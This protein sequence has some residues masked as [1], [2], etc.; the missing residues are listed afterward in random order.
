ML[1]AKSYQPDY[2]VEAYLQSID[3]V[4]IEKNGRNYII[5]PDKENITAGMIFYPGGKVNYKSYLPLLVECARNGILCIMPKMVHNLAIY[6]I[7]TANEV[8]S[9]SDYDYVSKWYIGGHSL[10]GAMASVYS[11]RNY[12]K[13][14]GLILL[15]AYS[16]KDLSSTGLKVL[17]IYGS[18]DGV[19]NR[20]NYNKNL[21]FFPADYEEHI[22]EGG[23]HCNFGSYGFQ[24]GDNEASLHG[25][26]QK[27]L[28]AE[29]IG[30]FCKK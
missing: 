16:P 23:N 9:S 12:E 13:L 26:V 19:L 10:G 3:D 6:N 4:K 1:P 20:K 5:S 30:M 21:S 22:L 7:S 14:E 18:K 8:L 29:Y 27:R 11:S 17:S 25:D 24:R 2:D 28:T 15:A